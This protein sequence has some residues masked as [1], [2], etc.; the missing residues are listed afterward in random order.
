MNKDA[1][2][3]DFLSDGS[4]ISAGRFVGTATFFSGTADE[5]NLT[6]NGERDCFVFHYPA[7]GI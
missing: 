7:D 3:I 4:V 6:S 5:I 1:G 2:G